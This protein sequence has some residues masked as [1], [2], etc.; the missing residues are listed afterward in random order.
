MK[1]TLAESGRAMRFAATPLRPAVRRAVTQLAVRQWQARLA[2]EQCDHRVDRGDAALNVARVQHQR[3]RRYDSQFVRNRKR[4]HDVSLVAW[5]HHDLRRAPD[6]A[7]L[8]ADDEL[9]DA[10]D[11]LVGRDRQAL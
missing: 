8:L 5:E 11:D 10:V 3:L 9:L 7:A 6:L 2:V 1:A 4:G